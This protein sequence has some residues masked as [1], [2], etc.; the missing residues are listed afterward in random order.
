MSDRPQAPGQS[1]VQHGLQRYDYRRGG[2][3]CRPQD[4]V[5]ASRD[6]RERLRLRATWADSLPTKA[7]AG[8]QRSAAAVFGRAGAGPREAK[9]DAWRID[10][11]LT[12]MAE[13]KATVQGR[14]GPIGGVDGAFDAIG[15]A[16][17]ARTHSARV[18]ESSRRGQDC[19]YDHRCLAIVEVDDC[20]LPHLVLEILVR[21]P[22]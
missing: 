8:V 13:A 15:E 21:R 17:T 20:S 16:Q 10:D 12:E 11:P 18:R 5:A 1:A 7:G 22:V 14:G 6:W 19:F 2:G 4:R 9:G 3:L